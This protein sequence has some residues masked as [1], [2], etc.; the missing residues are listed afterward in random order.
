MSISIN[1]TPAAGGG[2]FTVGSVSSQNLTLQVTGGI[3]PPGL[4]NL[5]LAEGTGI[6]I[7]TAGN[8]ATISANLTIPANLADLSDVTA[9]APSAGQ[10]LVWDGSAWN[11]VT[12]SVPT[13]L[14]DLANV[15]G[16]PTTGQVLAWDGSAWAPA[17]DK[18]GGSSNVANLADLSDVTFGN[19]TTGQV[20]AYNGTAWTAA[21][22]N[23]LTL[24]TSAGSDL[25]TAAIGT[26]GEAARADH[27]HNLP[28]FAEITN[29]TA[30]VT[31][32]L[33]LNAST[34]S[35]TLNGGT[36]GSG[37]LTLNCEANTHGVTIQGPPHSAAATY[38]LTLPTSAGAANQV[39][40]TDGSGGLSWAD[41]TAG[42]GITWAAEP[43]ASTST[44]TAGQIAYGSGFFYLHDGTEWRRAALSTFGTSTPTI[45]I[46]TQP[47]DL[48]LADG[49]SG[50]FTISATVSDGSS[51]SYQWQ[52]SDDNGSTWDTLTGS[53]GTTYSLSGVSSPD[54]GTQYRAIVSA[55]GASNVT[56][57]VAT[58]TVTAAAETFDLLTEASD[59]LM[60]ETGDSLDHDGVSGGGGNV[61]AWTQL[62]QSIAGTAQNY[63]FGSDLDLD[64]SG[65][66]VAAVSS[67]SGDIRV[68]DYSNGSGWVQRGS[69]LS[70]SAFSVSVS[71]DGNLV[72]SGETSPNTNT[73][74]VHIYQ[75]SGSTWS[76]LGSTLTG[77]AQYDNFGRSVSISGD[78]TH[79]A[80][81][82]FGSD[83]NGTQSGSFSVFE[84]SG[85]DWIQ[86]GSV[87]SGSQEDKLGA[88]ISISTTGTRV[89]VG[90]GDGDYAAVYEWSG[91]AWTQLGSNILQAP[92]L[93][94]WDVSLAGNGGR[95][96]VF[97]SSAYA[98]VFDW[99]GSAWVQVGDDISGFS[100][101]A[102]SSSG[103]RLLAI[104]PPSPNNFNS[105]AMRVLE[106][107]G[108]AWVQVGADITLPD[109]QSWLPVALNS[110][111]DVAAAGLA[112]NSSG[113]FGS[114]GTVEVYQ[115]Y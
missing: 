91:S 115:Y 16:T 41:Q 15:N 85:A 69:D 25:G 28:T 113:N 1:V 56:S 70:G 5:M 21:A 13:N 48:T 94:R 100:V 40:Q 7:A 103:D 67:N 57:N 38:T 33:T 79:V 114:A 2:I 22:D 71:D 26:S 39:L 98:Q 55:A 101:P 51:P 17:D 81:G 14:A 58:L 104:N 49:G 95:V 53:T 34:G 68:Y 97:G 65:T 111:G 73:G 75:W 82:A 24:S 88:S 66:T 60:T 61:S 50:N 76:Q 42:G 62:G 72:A 32:N 19:V 112:F 20:L 78:G 89:A 9:A 106:W 86:K 36:A 63:N 8:V 59:R 6:D 27:V 54:N 90:T 47:Q 99:S 84:W 102:I 30:T 93:G 18:T 37:S 3:G 107:N 74:E 23:A 110:V 35:V 87:I 43:S 64:A 77:S 83:A 12:L 80:V 96:A 108:T 29:G 105:R 44:G 31:G 11:G 52:N 92:A 46:T 10:V 4:G 109:D 45:T